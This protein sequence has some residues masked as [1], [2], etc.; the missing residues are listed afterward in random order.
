[1]QDLQRYI[2][3]SEPTGQPLAVAVERAGSAHVVSLQPRQLEQGIYGLGVS[4]FSHGVVSY[5]LARAPLA[6][7]Q[8]TAEL[9]ALIV[10]TL[11]GVAAGFWQGT[12]VPVDVA[13]PVGIAVLTSQVVSLGWTSL[14]HFMAVLSINLAFINLLP[15]PALDGGRLV[16]IGLE[17][18]R[19]RAVAREVEGRVHRW[20]F[21]VLLV[22]VAV[23]TY[24]DLKRFGGVFST[25]WDSIRLR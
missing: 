20:G 22:L 25:W 18:I 13:G 9:F 7:V 23:V 21:A 1:L 8:L 5:P 24:F 4:L 3:G 15:F 17:V 6:A 10:R 19:G 12:P 16:F 2:R 11:A 14:L